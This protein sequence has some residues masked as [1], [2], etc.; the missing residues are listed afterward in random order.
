[1]TQAN[2]T[3]VESAVQRLREAILAGELQP[4]QRLHQNQIAEMLGVSRTPLRS[5]LSMLAE[6]G[7]V[8][9]ESNKG[10]RV[11]EYSPEQIR[12]A[13]VVRAELEALACQLAAPN[14]TDDA[15]QELRTLA[16]TGDALLAGTS[17][18]PDNHA[19]YRDMNVT[20]HANIIK[21][22]ANPWLKEMIDRIYNV[23][24]ISDRVII[25]KDREIFLRTHDD[26]HR[27]AHA[28]G[29]RDGARASALM[30]E[31]VIFSIE[32]MLDQLEDTFDAQENKIYHVGI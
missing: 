22:A 24:L 16:D 20:F 17:L 19:A 6:T 25:W 1:M 27:I 31:H 8:V 13:F 10:F 11:R 7:L 5:A 26:H 29:R 2:Q 15:V 3:N 4:G 30:R 9:Y 12:H 18:R 21:Y 14:M 23:P 32:Y 28:L